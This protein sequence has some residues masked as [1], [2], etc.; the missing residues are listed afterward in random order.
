MGGRKPMLMSYQFSLPKLSVPSI[1]DTM[2]RVCMQHLLNHISQT[3]SLI[4]NVYLMKYICRI[5]YW[6]SCIN[7][8]TC[9]FSFFWLWYWLY[10]MEMNFLLSAK[11]TML[12]NEWSKCR[13]DLI[14]VPD[15]SAAF[16]GRG[17]IFQ[18][19]EAGKRV[20]GWHRQ[21]TAAL[22]DVEVV[23]GHKL[24]VWLVGG[25]CL[26]QWPVSPHD[27]QQLLCSGMLSILK[28]QL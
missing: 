8:C 20:W 1:H 18:N 4:S 28:I 2:N 5:S 3:C 23:L 17:E 9:K 14:S 15:L 21:K 7:T 12:Q 25:L 13:L 6:I 16:I 19:G 10:E 11:I 26:P 27:Q 24:R 22:P